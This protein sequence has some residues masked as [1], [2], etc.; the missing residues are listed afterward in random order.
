LDEPVAAFLAYTAQAGD[1]EPNF[2]PEHG[3]AKNLLVFDFGGGTCDVAIFR[4]GRNAD[5]ELTAAHLSVSRYH[6]LG[7]GD[8]NR[9]VIHEVLLPQLLEQNGLDSFA[10]SFEDKRHRIQPALLGVAEA[11]KQKPSIEIA[12]LRKPGRWE[13]IDKEDVVQTLPGVYPVQLADRTLKLESPKL[14]LVDFERV[15]APFLDPILLHPREDEY[16]IAC[17]IFAPIED[18]LL[19]GR[20]DR[21][22]IDL[23]R[24]A[25]GSSLIPQIADAIAGYFERARILKFPSRE[26]AQTAISKGAALHAFSLTLRGKPFIRPVCHDDICLQT[27]RGPLGLIPK[28]AELPF[29]AGGGYLRHTEIKAPETVKVGAEGNI[30]IQV[31]AGEEQRPLFEKIWQIRG[32]VQKGASL[33]LDIR[34]DENQVL[35]LQMAA[36]ARRAPSRPASKTR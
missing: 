14:G 23:C 9:A 24:L 21:N 25:G 33:W 27:Q 5:G 34:F 28:G 30:R 1:S 13:K 20:L 6:R 36:S 15:L 4:L 12:R 18:A 22:R 7:G 31:I 32:P 29:P 19:R 10:L 2:L 3:Q 8:I 26:D 17:S 35:D 11:F 16:R